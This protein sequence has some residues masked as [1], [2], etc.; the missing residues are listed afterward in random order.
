MLSKLFDHQSQLLQNNIQH[1]PQNNTRSITMVKKAK[2]NRSHYTARA[3]NKSQLIV[4]TL[5]RQKH[6]NNTHQH[7]A[8]LDKQQRNTIYLPGL[9]HWQR[10]QHRHSRI[11]QPDWITNASYWLSVSAGDTEPGNCH[12]WWSQLAANFT[13]KIRNIH[14]TAGTTDEPPR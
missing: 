11:D 6:S 12:C 3:L 2:T 8:N 7:K 14:Y 1:T 13:R 5:P 9:R 10:K 4:T